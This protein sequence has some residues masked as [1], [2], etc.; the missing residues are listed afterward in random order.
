MVRRQ[1]RPCSWIKK[2]AFVWLLA[3]LLSWPMGMRA[4]PP[5][6]AAPAEVP[7]QIN[8]SQLEVDHAKQE[9]V[10]KDQVVARYKDIILYT[11]LLKIHYQAKPAAPDKKPESPLE[12]VGIE[13]IDRI[14]ALG[15]VRLVQEDRVATGER[16]VY[17]PQEEKIVLS[18]NP[19]LWRGQNSIRGEEVIFY[20]KE[21]RAVVR[22]QATQRVEAVL[23]PSSKT[24][25]PGKDRPARP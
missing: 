19:Q 17:Y 11:D 2:Q 13:K 12:S 23:Y 16:A 8:A 4:A 21:N 20:I 6:P 10:F 1:E 5:A 7:L 24:A 18:G 14:E 22:G 15:K 3:L 25:L 9:I